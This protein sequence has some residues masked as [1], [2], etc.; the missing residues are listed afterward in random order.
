M[1]LRSADEIQDGNPQEILTSDL[2]GLAMGMCREATNM[3]GGS[4]AWHLGSHLR[5]TVGPQ[6]YQGR[7][8]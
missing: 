4:L 8:M 7:Y 6:L 5:I 1:V 3:I 2:V